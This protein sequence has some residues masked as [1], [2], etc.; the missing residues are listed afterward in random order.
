MFYV[1]ML[2]KGQLFVNFLILCGFLYEYDKSIDYS[3]NQE[4]IFLLD[5][6]D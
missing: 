2:N 6:K 5:L 1:S 4:I 3:R